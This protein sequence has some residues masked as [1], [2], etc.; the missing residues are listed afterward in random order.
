LFDF[1]RTWSARDQNGSRVTGLH[2]IST[3]EAMRVRR[4]PLAALCTIAPLVLV[5]SACS[6]SNAGPVVGTRGE[7][8][9]RSITNPPQGSGNCTTFGTG[10][11]D[12]VTNHTTVDIRLYRGTHCTNPLGRP[13]D[14]LA[15]TFSLNSGGT[16]LWRSF[17]TVGWPPPV[18]PN[19][20]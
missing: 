15:T 1:F 10:G 9:T 6:D 5:A 11:V 12:H 2:V 19:A 17:S 18:P 13:S 20:N 4:R 16:G 14:Y 7:V 3:G 8:F